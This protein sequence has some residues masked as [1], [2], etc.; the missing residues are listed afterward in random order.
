MSIENKEYINN[1]NMQFYGATGY[2][3]KNMF[4]DLSSDAKAWSRERKSQ[5]DSLFFWLDQAGIPIDY[6]ECAEL[7]KGGLDSLVIPYETTII[8][9]YGNTFPKR[10]GFSDGPVIL[11]NFSVL[12]GV[13][14]IDAKNSDI[15]DFKVIN[16]TEVETFFIHNPYDQTSVANLME[17][18]NNKYN[19][20]ILA[21]Y[22]RTYDKDYKAKIAIIDR[23]QKNLFERETCV[24]ETMYVGDNYYSFIATKPSVKKLKRSI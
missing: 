11:G 22:G 24:R 4:G 18:H 12:S 2:N 1:L 3:G 21:V 6:K 23:F 15:A 5:G 20:I 10:K 9:P 16:P 14:I 17:L 7:N 8:T 19:N 13:P